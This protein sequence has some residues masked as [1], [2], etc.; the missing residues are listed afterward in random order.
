[1]TK[2]RLLTTF[3]LAI[4][5]IGTLVAIGMH[6]Q[7]VVAANFTPVS[8]T[9]YLDALGYA[10][11][12]TASVVQAAG[13]ETESES[14]SETPELGTNTKRVGKKDE[15]RKSAEDGSPD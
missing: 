3:A 4:L 1:M 7:P 6:S 9:S 15:S 10:A 5:L 8:A 12:M 14:E 2:H 11:Q 13:S